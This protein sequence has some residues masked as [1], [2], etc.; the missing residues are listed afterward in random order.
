[1]PLPADLEEG[2]GITIH[3][4]HYITRDGDLLCNPL[5]RITW[6]QQLTQQA[7]RP[8]HCPKCAALRPP[9]QHAPED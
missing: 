2:W 7:P 5:R 6:H 3:G 1:M 9:P 8:T 4:E